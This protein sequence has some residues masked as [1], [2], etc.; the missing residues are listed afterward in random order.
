MLLPAT[1][2]RKK[3]YTHG[4]EIVAPFVQG[5]PLRVAETPGTLSEKQIIILWASGQIMR[6]K[7]GNVLLREQR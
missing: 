1:S 7:I 5:A 2:L 4:V 3:V 6:L